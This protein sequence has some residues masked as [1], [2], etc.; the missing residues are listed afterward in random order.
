MA[1]R[2]AARV[3]ADGRI[4]IPA[5]VREELGVEEG[6]YVTGELDGLEGE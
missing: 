2:F 3:I 5:H 6:D 1:E 4:T